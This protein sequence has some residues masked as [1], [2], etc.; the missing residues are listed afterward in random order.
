MEQ[1]WEQKWERN[2][3]AAPHLHI[4]WLHDV[5]AE[6]EGQVGFPTTTTTREAVMGAST[7]PQ[8]ECPVLVH[9]GSGGG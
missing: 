6:C 5:G 3:A 7:H 2:R 9:V 8:L 1:K 4:S